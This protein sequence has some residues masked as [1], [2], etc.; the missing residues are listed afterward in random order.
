M[1][2]VLLRE[3]L[4]RAMGSVL[5]L[6]LLALQGALG[7]SPSTSLPPAKT[8]EEIRRNLL[9]SLDA[10][11]AFRWV[12]TQG[13][14]A[15]YV[16]R[17]ELFPGLGKAL[18]GKKLKVYVGEGEARVPWLDAAGVRYSIFVMP[19]KPA[20]EEGVLIAPGSYMLGR[21]PDRKG[22]FLLVL[23]KDVAA[24]MARVFAAYEAFA[25]EVVQ[26]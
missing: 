15:I 10:T 26:R 18:K 16:G 11:E 19:G 7:A 14:S 21:D 20:S 23:S 13:E 3:H 1:R 22:K 8:Q 12:S 17:Q 24:I 25:K 6:G 5:V 4:A 2:K 9:R